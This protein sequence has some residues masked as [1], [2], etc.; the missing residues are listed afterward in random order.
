MNAWDS[1][2]DELRAAT[3]RAARRRF[4]PF[5]A[6]R[7]RPPWLASA[8]GL[9][10]AVIVLL[11]A[12]R[13]DGPGTIPAD[14]R[15]VA[16]PTAAAVAPQ[17]PSGLSVSR[18][19]V[20]ADQLAAFAVLRRPQT[21][22]EQSEVL[23][24]FKGVKGERYAGIRADAIRVLARTRGEIAAL[25]PMERGRFGPDTNTDVLD[26][27]CLLRA[28]GR[29]YGLTCGALADVL[30]GQVRWTRP[31]AG[32]A[33]DVAARVRL[34][35]RGGRTITLTPRNNFYDAAAIDPSLVGLQPP[36]WINA[37]GDHVRLTP[38]P[39]PTPAP[40]P[41]TTPQAMPE[42][43]AKDLRATPVAPDDASLKEALSLLD[44]S[45]KVVR[46][47]KVRGLQGHVLLTRKGG[48][49]CLSTPDPLTDHPDAERGVGCV[50]DS[51][52]QRRGAYVGLV[53][54]DGKNRITVTVK[55]DQRTIRIRQR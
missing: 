27:L 45:H 30:A 28:K 32:L 36:R 2:E 29:G 24:L 43:D 49:W 22:G 17:L 11:V 37:D 13:G 54:A 8:A 5:A 52:F 6:H 21:P 44:D 55:P 10:A 19:P 23:A 35:V 40:S 39:T 42:L 25:V 20:P 31:P 41:A 51:R 14:E 33:P 46:A 34:R 50:P 12:V 3:R 4:R 9:A 48:Q 47:W 26:P 16:S 38:T 18:S 1:L 7:R 15:A 53:P